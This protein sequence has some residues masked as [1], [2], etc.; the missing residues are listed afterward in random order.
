MVWRRFKIEVAS[1]H[2][3]DGIGLVDQVIQKVHIVCFGLRNE[4]KGW[5]V[6]PEIQLGVDFDAERKD[7]LSHE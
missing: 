6:A 4:K 1:I 7:C 5:D 2:N 3:V